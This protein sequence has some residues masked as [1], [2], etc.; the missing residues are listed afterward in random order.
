MCLRAG[1]EMGNWR[2]TSHHKQRL[3]VLIKA[4]TSHTAFN[5]IPFIKCSLFVSSSVGVCACKG[6]GEK[7]REL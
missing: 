7:V 3:S 5:V 2:S 4:L 1:E 6:E